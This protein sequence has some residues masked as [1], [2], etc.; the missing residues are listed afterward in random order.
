MIP[1]KP[2]GRQLAVRRASSARAACVASALAAYSG[3]REGPARPG[4]P[5]PPHGPPGLLVRCL[6]DPEVAAPGA[7]GPFAAPAPRPPARPPPPP[8]PTSQTPVKSGSLASAVQSAAVGALRAT[9]WPT[10]TVAHA[11]MAAKE[12]KSNLACALHMFI[13]PH[14]SRISRCHTNRGAAAPIGASHKCL[15]SKGPTAISDSYI[16]RRQVLHDGCRAAT[17]ACSRERAGAV[18]EGPIEQR[19]LGGRRMLT[20]RSCEICSSK[21]AEQDKCLWYLA[22]LSSDEGAR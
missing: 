9:F 21:L 3:V 20:L 5:R 11:T 16:R 12:G 6:H 2:G 22:E 7:P 14:S 17:R 1:G 13:R 18:P 15:S 10:A 4:P 19:V 8:N